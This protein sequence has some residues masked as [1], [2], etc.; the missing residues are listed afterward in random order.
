MENV[1]YYGILHAYG[2][3]VRDHLLAQCIL[4]VHAVVGDE[5]IAFILFIYK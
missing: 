1:S 3:P 4:G 2:I 5:A